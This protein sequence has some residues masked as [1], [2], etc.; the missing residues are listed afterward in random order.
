MGLEQRAHA[1]AQEQPSA[2]DAGEHAPHAVTRRAADP[3]HDRRH[4]V[5]AQGVLERRFVVVD[6]HVRADRE[7]GGG[8]RGRDRRRIRVAAPGDR[9]AHADNADGGAQG[10]PTIARRTRSTTSA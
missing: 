8:Q 7:A 1:L 9:R 10:H 4:A 2:G 5:E 3:R 6:H